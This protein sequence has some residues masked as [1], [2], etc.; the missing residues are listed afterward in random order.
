M[1][2]RPYDSKPDT[3]AHI[4]RV[5]SLLQDVIDDLHARLTVHDDSKLMEPERPVFDR[6][7]PKLKALT[8]GSD[9]YK[10]SLAEMGEALT[11]HYA[12]NRHHPEHFDAGI[13]GMNLVD[14]IEMLCDW[15]AATERH[16]DGSIGKS[17]EINKDRFGIPYDLMT[18]LRNTVRD[19]GWHE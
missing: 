3:M 10:A 14:L 18:I 17:L 9:E 4:Y 13:S 8:Y 7:T 12:A 5:A 15:K 1:T 6:V 11:H 2:D 19:W 16:A